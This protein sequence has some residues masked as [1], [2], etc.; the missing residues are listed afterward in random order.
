MASHLDLPGYDVIADATKAA[1]Q[2]N[3]ASAHVSVPN[4]LF[5]LREV[6]QLIRNHGN[7]IFEN[8]SSLNLGWQFGIKPLLSDL[9]KIFDFGSAYNKRLNLLNDLESGQLKRRISLGTD[10]AEKEESFVLESY[11][12]FATSNATITTKRERWAVVKWQP[13]AIYKTDSTFEERK[14]YVLRS[15][16]G[17]TVASAPRVIWDAL[18]WS[19]MVDWFTTAGDFIT[20]NNNSIAR[21]SGQVNV[22]VKTETTRI[23]KLSGVPGWVTSGTTWTSTAESKRR[24]LRNPGLTAHVPFLS[25]R[26]LSIIGSLYVLKR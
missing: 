15:M 23:D 22:M 2:T 5:E 1:S 20:A 7:N 9:A 18:P 4:F 17:L 13:G 10:E 19:W 8:A 25:G 16:L 21:L 14:K 6:P 26:Q 24:F 11:L 3:P 12:F